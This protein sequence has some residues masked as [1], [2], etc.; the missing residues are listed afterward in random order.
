MSKQLVSGKAKK[1]PVTSP[2]P[3]NVPAWHPLVMAQM[4]S[5]KP[6]LLFEVPQAAA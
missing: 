4:E 3:L 6:E 5:K 2:A 1:K